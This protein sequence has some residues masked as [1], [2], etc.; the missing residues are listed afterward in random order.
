MKQNGGAKFSARV[1]SVEWEGSCLFGALQYEDGRGERGFRHLLKIDGLG[2][3]ARLLLTYYFLHKTRPEANG[4]AI[5]FAGDFVIPVHEADRL[6]F[7]AGFKDIRG[8]FQLEIL[9]HGHHVAVG[10]D[11]AVGMLDDAVD[12]RAVGIGGRVEG[13]F[14]AADGAFVMVRLF[15]NI[16]HFTHR[17]GRLAHSF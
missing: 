11:I 3:A 1:N 12:G 8:A 15:K 14:V 9:D 4:D 2:R 13:P 17:T 7:G 5:H 10:E 16:G 6:G